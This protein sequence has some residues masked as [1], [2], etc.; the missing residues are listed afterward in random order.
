MIAYLESFYNDNNDNEKYPSIEINS[1]GDLSQLKIQ[2][3]D[4]G[5][6]YYAESFLYFNPT[7]H[8]INGKFY[9]FELEIVFK[10]QPNSN[11]RN[12]APGSGRPGG[13]RPGGGRPGR[14][15]PPTSGG[16][17]T[18]TAPAAQ[19]R[20]VVLFEAGEQCNP[21]FEPISSMAGRIDNAT[22]STTTQANVSL[23]RLIP[24]DTK[25]VV[26]R[27]SQLTNNCP[28]TTVYAVA[29]TPN[30][31]SKG[32][33]EKF[34]NWENSSGEQGKSDH[35]SQSPLNARVLITGSEQIVDCSN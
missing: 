31:I 29:L 35:P 20:I 14:P 11:T 18:T 33:L 28:Q 1:T 5:T 27:G 19:I 22:N 25:F 3:Y 6:Y 32:Q 12:S 8:S 17:S 9:D 15:K 7:I 24:D 2:S 30:Y 23:C 4:S 16:G 21:F 13:G 34:A 10:Y 26:Y